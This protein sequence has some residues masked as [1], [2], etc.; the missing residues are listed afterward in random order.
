VVAR[1]A[2]TVTAGYASENDDRPA[3]GGGFETWL[4]A[5]NS[6]RAAISCDRWVT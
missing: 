1:A 4:D 6:T 3:L 2:R 5:G